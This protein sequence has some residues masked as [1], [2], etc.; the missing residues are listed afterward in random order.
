[1]VK[2][3]QASGGQGKLKTPWDDW[4]ALA[5]QEDNQGICVGVFV[6]PRASRTG[7]DGCR[8]GD[9]K[10]RVAAPPVE[11]RA[12]A[13]CIELLARLCHIPPCRVKLKSGRQG[14]SKVFRLQGISREEFVARLAQAQSDKKC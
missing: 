14:R 4:A 8:G 12:N 1:M 3:N 13:A 9:L 6:Q 10:I 2:D 7:V 11:G 5:V